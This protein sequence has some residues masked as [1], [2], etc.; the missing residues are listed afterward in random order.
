MRRAVEKRTAPRADG[1]F[2]ARRRLSLL[3]GALLCLLI[4]CSPPALGRTLHG[5]D[6]PD[7]LR[8]G[9]GSD[10]LRGAGWAELWP[11]AVVLWGM[12]F[13]VLAIGSLRFRKRLA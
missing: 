3:G 7:R 11:C 10:S 8:G 2:V 1:P 6:S 5:T 12:A 4:A 9:A 13:C